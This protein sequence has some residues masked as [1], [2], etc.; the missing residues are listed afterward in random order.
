MAANLKIELD[1]GVT[2]YLS[3]MVI[4]DTYSSILEGSPNDAINQKVMYAHLETIERIWGAKPTHVMEPSCF[5]NERRQQQLFPVLMAGDL[6][7]GTPVKDS[8]MHGSHL[9]LVQFH[10]EFT[11]T[12]IDEFV[13][14]TKS[15]AWGQHANDFQW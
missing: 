7:S 4:L 10:R 13:K 3:S 14:Q 8:E 15:I 12:L 2:V 11:L 1:C 5:V 6:W 9:I